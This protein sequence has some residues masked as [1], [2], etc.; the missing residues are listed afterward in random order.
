VITRLSKIE[1]KLGNDILSVRVYAPGVYYIDDLPE[2]AKLPGVTL[3]ISDQLNRSDVLTVDYFSGYDVLKKGKN[4]FDV[5]ALYHH[6]WDID[7]PHRLK[8]RKG[9]YL[10]ANYRYGILDNVTAGA[11]IQ[12]RGGS[13][14][15]D[16][17]SVFS[18]EFGVISPGIAFSNS[19]PRV[20]KSSRAFGA[21]VF[22]ALPQNDLGL[23]AETYF[24]IT[25][26]GFGDLETTDDL[27]E[28]YNKFMNKYLT[29]GNLR[30][31]FANSPTNEASKQFVA[32]VYSK[33]IFGITPA[34][35]FSG[36]WSDSS[37]LREYTFSFATKLFNRITITVSAGITY[38]DPYK[39]INRKS[40]DRRLTVACTIPMGDFEIAGTYSHHDDDRL[41]SYAKIAYTPSE[42]KGLEVTVERDTKP[43]FS[44][45]SVA[46]KYDGTY[47]NAKIDHSVKNTYA[48]H[49]GTRSA[50]HSNQQR[51]FFGTSV[52][53]SGFK[54][55]RK[56]SF[57]ILRSAAPAKK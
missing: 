31:R 16:G 2:E 38:D 53:P 34:F 5:T 12:Q 27:N 4:D 7:D 47:F 3:K 26:K 35:V 17:T 56:S 18:G 43:G 10:S 15:L 39:G 19:H 29:N 40:P 11:G 55:Y 6:R 1:C 51:F 42:I 37:R 44:S 9:P 46:I 20:G 24:A 33:P 36:W 14:L 23:S 25:E 52:S 30:Q 49:K 22:Y 8:Y 21:V 50:A 32:R 28:S 13:Y 45:P 41:R 54:P 48:D 57:N